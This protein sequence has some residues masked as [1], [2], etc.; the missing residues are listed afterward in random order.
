MQLKNYANPIYTGC[1]GEK[2]NP[3][4]IFEFSTPEK[5]KRTAQIDIFNIKGQKVKSLITSKN[6][7]DMAKSA[8]L[9]GKDTAKFNP[10]TYSLIWNAKDENFRSLPSGVYLYQLSIDGEKKAVN[11]LMILK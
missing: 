7:S 5:I 3:Y 4:T 10:N 8:G 1:T 9:S 2:G 11:K 6:I